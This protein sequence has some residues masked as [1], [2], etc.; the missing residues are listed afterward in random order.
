MLR[1]RLS[2]ICATLFSVSGRIP[3]LRDA[4]KL[5]PKLRTALNIKEGTHDKSNHQTFRF[6]PTKLTK[7][8]VK[9]RNIYSLLY[10][11]NFEN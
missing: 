8:I 11:L 3:C 9:L 1:E 2:I 7:N 6:L 5:L 10:T 4:T